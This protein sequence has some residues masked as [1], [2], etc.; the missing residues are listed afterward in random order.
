M[1]DKGPLTKGSWFRVQGFVGT[2]DVHTVEG[3]EPTWRV[4]LGLRRKRD[5]HAVEGL[6]RAEL[7]SV[8]WSKKELFVLLY[9]EVLQLTL[10]CVVN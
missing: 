3:G 4:H 8:S 5:F 6:V 2:R 7:T 9:L 1:K 10:A